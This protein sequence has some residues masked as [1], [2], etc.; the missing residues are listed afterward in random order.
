MLAKSSHFHATAAAMLDVCASTRY[1]CTLHIK[2][3]PYLRVRRRFFIRVVVLLVC[4]LRNNNNVR[5]CCE[6]LVFLLIF[7]VYACFYVFLGNFSPYFFNDLNVIPE[8]PVESHM[9]FTT[10]RWQF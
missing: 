5:R 8:I 3:L 10:E 9:K 7:S 4:G 6:V 1:T 2:V